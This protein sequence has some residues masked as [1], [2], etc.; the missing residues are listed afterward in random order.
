MLFLKLF[1]KFCI[2]TCNIIWIDHSCICSGYFLKLFGNFFTKSVECSKSNH[3]NL[4]TF[5]SYFVF[6][7]ITEVFCNLFSV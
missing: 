3:C 4:R 1:Q 5:L 7:Q 2:N 6:V